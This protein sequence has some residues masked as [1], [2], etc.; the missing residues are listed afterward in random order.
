MKNA[1]RCLLYFSLF[2][3]F[4]LQSN[5]YSL[6]SRE[7]HLKAAF[8]RY[9]AKFIEWPQE[10]LKDGLIHL[11]VIGKMP[12]LQSLYS[13]D[14]KVTGD[15]RIKVRHIDTVTQTKGCHIVFLAKTEKAVSHALLHAIENQPI[16]SFG[17]LDHF[18]E[19]GGAMNFYTSHNRLGIM[20]NLPAL[21]KAGLHINPHLLWLVTAILP[22]GQAD[23]A[24]FETKEGKNELP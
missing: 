16:L 24:S 8:L 18:T 2:F 11:C 19:E 4:L 14:N 3:P 6:E 17:D 22:F 15:Y 1:L 21:K 12:S 7:Y 13:I 23:W 20:V 9:V 5:D 10:T